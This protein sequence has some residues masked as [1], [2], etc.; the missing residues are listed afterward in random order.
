MVLDL[1]EN[2]SWRCAAVDT[3]HNTLMGLGVNRR[4]GCGFWLRP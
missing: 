3:D 4:A 1:L 2:G